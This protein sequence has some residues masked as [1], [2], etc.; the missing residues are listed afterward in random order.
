M[1]G[2]LTGMDDSGIYKGQTCTNVIPMCFPHLY[3]LFF[4]YDVIQVHHIVLTKACIYIIHIALLSHFNDK[5]QSL[6]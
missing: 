3:L 6:K 4:I 2:E 5:K 1:V